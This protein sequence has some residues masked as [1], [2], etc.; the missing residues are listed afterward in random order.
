MISPTAFSQVYNA[1][2]TYGIG[3]EVLF[4]LKVSDG[5][6]DRIV[7]VERGGYHGEQRLTV[8]T[9]YSTDEALTWIDG[10]SRGRER[11]RSETLDK[12]P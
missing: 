4:E 10:Y 6:R 5:T 1:A 12:A 7:F 3:L 11:G 9:C 2:A 8:A